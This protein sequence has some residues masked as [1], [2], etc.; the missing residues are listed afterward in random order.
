M[1]GTTSNLLT[2]EETSR[3]LG[4]SASTVW[5][6][7][8]RGAVRSVRQ[9]GRRLIAED[10]VAQRIGASRDSRI[11]PFTRDNPVFRLAGAGRSGGRGPGSDDKYGILES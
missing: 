8:R 5:R 6:L 4:V 2:I 3:R 1:S 7:I 10:S 11:P 9:D